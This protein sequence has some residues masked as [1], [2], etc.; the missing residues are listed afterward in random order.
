MEKATL[1]VLVSAWPGMIPASA[2]MMIEDSTVSSL[3][4]PMVKNLTPQA[5]PLA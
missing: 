1:L 3:L 4:M 2:P 5:R